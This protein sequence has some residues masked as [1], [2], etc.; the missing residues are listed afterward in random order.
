MEGI[1][2]EVYDI[3]NAELEAGIKINSIRL[4]GGA[5]KSPMWC[6]MLADIFKLP[7]QLLSAGE[8]G[9]LGAALYAGIGVGA[10][11]NCRDAAEKAVQ[12][13]EVFEP[14]PE[15]FAAYDKAYQRF[16]NVYNALDNRIF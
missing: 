3:I 8:T 5:A 14:N 12:L 10:Y 2:F 13:T 15:K 4:T 16:I 7:I 9:C 6:Q 1:S 11:E